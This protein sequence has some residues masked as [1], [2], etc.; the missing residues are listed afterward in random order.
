MFSEL[1]STL[2]L[3]V[4]EMNF[5]SLRHVLNQLLILLSLRKL[6]RCFTSR[7]LG[8][9]VIIAGRLISQTSTLSAAQIN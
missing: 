9:N 1:I 8:L 2:L 7:E 5:G 4:D 3:P 6:L